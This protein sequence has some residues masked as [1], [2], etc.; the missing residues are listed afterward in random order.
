MTAQAAHVDVKIWT[1]DDIVAL[2]ETSNKAVVRA[3]KQLYARQTSDEQSTKTTRVANGRG[4]NA[5]DAPFL[6]DIA[7]KLPRYNDQMTPKQTAVAR[8]ML[9]KYWRQLLEVIEEN[10]GQVSYSAS[11]RR[12]EPAF[13]PPSDFATPVVSEDAKPALSEVASSPARFEAFSMS[14]EWTI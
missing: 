6:S 11:K 14:G 12:S 9:K 8:K 4:F 7:R 10:G 5:K 1:R 2:L 3:I 13:P